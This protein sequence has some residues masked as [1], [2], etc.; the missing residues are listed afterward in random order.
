VR[1]AYPSVKGGP[2]G[3]SRKRIH[4][5]EMLAER[6][7]YES[8]LLMRTSRSYAVTND[9]LSTASVS[10]LQRSGLGLVAKPY[11]F[12]HLINEETVT[13]KKITE[14]VIERWNRAAWEGGVVEEGNSLQRTKRNV[15]GD[16]VHQLFGVATD[17]QLQ[18]QL[19]G[20]EEMRG[21]VADTLTR[22]LYFEKELTIAIGNIT[23]EE[24]LEGK[25]RGPEE[26]HNLDRVR[27]I[28]MRGYRLPLMENV[29]RLRGR[30]GHC[31]D[32]GSEHSACGLFVG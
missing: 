24:K 4:A 28:R 23:E 30:V 2:R 3:E 29:E 6:L 16:I 11:R 26:K 27:G 13:I 8:A 17:K 18:Q 25:L 5:R 21:K 10:S 14:K 1:E 22:Q 7:I 32:W 15:F 9:R 31:C 20:D 19:R 12:P